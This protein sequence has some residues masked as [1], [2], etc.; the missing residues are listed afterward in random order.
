MAGEAAGPTLGDSVSPIH[1]MSSA[2]QVT[3]TIDSP[4]ITAPIDLVE[5]LGDEPRNPGTEVRASWPPI[6]NQLDGRLGDREGAELL[7]VRCLRHG[8]L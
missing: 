4:S 7:D 1:L 2:V 3:Q 6:L 5:G 8:G